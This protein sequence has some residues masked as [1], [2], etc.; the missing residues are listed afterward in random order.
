MLVARC[1]APLY[2]QSGT[3]TLGLKFF[4]QGLPVPILALNGGG[5]HAPR[6]TPP[7]YPPIPPPPPPPP[8]QGFPPGGWPPP[9][10]GSQQVR[11]PP[12]TGLS[13][14]D[15][16]DSSL[17]TFTAAMQG[18]V[19]AGFSMEVPSPAPS[20]P[21]GKIATLSLLHLRFAAVEPVT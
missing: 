7:P 20:A 11:P 14:L 6:P 17:H 5:G 18:M 13:A 3:H 8:K 19:A 16:S 21:M 1:G 2:P 12:A 15:L 4:Q 9:V 10:G